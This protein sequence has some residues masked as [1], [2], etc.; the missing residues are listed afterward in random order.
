[1]KPQRIPCVIE[2]VSG[3]RIKVRNAGTPS[4]SLEKFIR[5]MLLN[6]AAPTRIKNRGAG[7]SGH[8][9]GQRPNEKARQKTKRGED[10]GQAGAAAHTDS[11]DAFDI[12][13]A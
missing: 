1:M 7:K 6:I 2:K 13:C 3:I 11:G 8:H 4:S 9:A 12:G 5:P 10:R